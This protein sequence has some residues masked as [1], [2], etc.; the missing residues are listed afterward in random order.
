MSATPQGVENPRRA[1]LADIVKAR[2]ETLVSELSEGGASAEDIAAVQ[3]VQ[4]EVPASDPKKPAELTDEAW[5][6]MSDEDK[7]AALQA[8]E[9]PAETGTEVVPVVEEPAREKLKI[10]GQEQEVEVSKILEAGRRALQKD[11]AADKRLEEATRAREE[12]ERLRLKMEQTLAQAQPVEKKPDPQASILAKED[13]RGI[14]HKIQYGSEEEAAQALVDYGTKMAEL[15]QSGRLT[16]TELNH[17][18]D[19]REAQQF[20]KSNYADVVGDENL[21]E[22]F[23]GKVNRKL[24]AGD[25]RSYQEICKETGDELRAW[26][27]MPKTDPTPAGGSRALAAERKRSTV[28]VPAAAARQQPPTQPTA[29]PSTSELV[30]KARAARGQA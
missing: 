3:G 10:D 25:S 29:P 20:V 9:V 21:K 15:G 11:M 27:G 23:V 28:S 30:A 8:A 7:A 14:V 18:L 16:H 13:L 12:A 4:P 5:A 24:A 22:L 2:T 19:L 17:A 6:A 1:A 26:K